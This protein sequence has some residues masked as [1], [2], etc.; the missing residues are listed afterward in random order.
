M[1]A[2]LEL[3]KQADAN[4]GKKSTT[5]FTAEDRALIGRYAAENGNAAAVK[6]FKLSHSVGE[7]RHCGG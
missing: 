4:A 2:S 6:R 1:E 3:E 5:S 7:S